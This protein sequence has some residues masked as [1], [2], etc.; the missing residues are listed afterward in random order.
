MEYRTMLRLQKC[1]WLNVHIFF[2]WLF[3]V[4]FFLYVK[5]NVLG[6][7]TKYLSLTVFTLLTIIE[8]ARL[9][10]GHYGNLSCR[11]PELA[12][13]LLLTT[14]MQMPLVSFFLF[15]PYLLNTPTELILHASLWSVTI[16]E[17]IFSYL[18]LK[19]ASSIAKSI[20]LKH[21]KD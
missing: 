1:L 18:A 13:F 10:L 7:L 16:M 20:Y 11:V 14:L 5:L 9:Y 3:V 6:H 8:S 17:I 4:A 21:S 2:V 12:G 15:N 19:Q